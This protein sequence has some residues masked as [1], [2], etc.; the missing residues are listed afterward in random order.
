MALSDNCLEYWPL[1]TNSLVGAINGTTLTA[2]N[3]AF[4]ATSPGPCWKPSATQPYL[5]TN[6]ITLSEPF[7]VAVMVYVGG[8]AGSAATFVGYLRGS[9]DYYQL[10]Q[11]ATTNKL[12]S[13]ARSGA[14]GGNGADAGGVSGGVFNNCAGIYVGPTERYGQLAGTMS[15]ADTTNVTPAGALHNLSLGGLWDGATLSSFVDVNWRFKHFA[16]W[17]RQLTDAELDSY[18]TDPTQV[19][20]SG[21]A[22][23]SDPPRRRFPLSI[24]HH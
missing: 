16:V 24:L 19:I 20:P 15:A 11:S 7:T 21:G 14:S 5:W 8:G 3:F 17:S 13:K 12:L 6:A 9:A 2:V 1:T 18:F 10:Y 23:T 4:E 22:A